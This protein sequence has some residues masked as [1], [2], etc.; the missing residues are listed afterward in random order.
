MWTAE[1]R[2]QFKKLSSS[3]FPHVCAQMATCT[4]LFFLKWSNIQDHLQLTITSSP[5]TAMTKKIWTNSYPLESLLRI[6]R[7]IRSYICLQCTLPSPWYR[8]RNA[9]KNIFCLPQNIMSPSSQ[10][11]PKS[12]SFKWN[13]S[14]KCSCAWEDKKLPGFH[15]LLLPFSCHVSTQ[16]VR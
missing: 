7:L 13:A 8:R 1:G 5:N 16:K 10:M 9:S 6:V 3:E 2:S 11:Y 15:N 14:K 4:Q 12:N